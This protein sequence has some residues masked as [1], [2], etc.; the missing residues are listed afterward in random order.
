VRRGAPAATEHLTPQELQVA[1]EVAR[2]S[3]NREAAAALFLSPKTVEFH[4]RNIYRK[5]SIRSRTE[6][7]R[8]VISDSSSAAVPSSPAEARH[9][10]DRN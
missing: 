6:L 2:G 10:D 3:T 9:G 5:L 7:V 4:L 1:L 8:V